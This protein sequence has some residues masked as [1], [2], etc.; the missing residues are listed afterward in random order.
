M[1][2]ISGWSCLHVQ[3][4][5]WNRSP[6][7]AEGLC[8]SRVARQPCPPHVPGIYEVGHE[9]MALEGWEVQLGGVVRAMLR[10]LVLSWVSL[11]LWCL[12]IAIGSC[13]ACGPCL[14]GCCNMVV[15]H[16]TSWLMEM[17]FPP[18]QSLLSPTFP[19]W[20]CP[21]S[22]YISLLPL[23]WISSPSTNQVT[24]DTESLLCFVTCR[25]GAD[26]FC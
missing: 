12:S 4:H 7:H 16:F 19:F 5:R 13:V 22:G 26:L 21:H 11:Y 8:D 3:P 14:E 17:A 9:Y 2:L 1:W 15:L 25:Y 6:D 24:D 20:H 10:L 23:S 18:V